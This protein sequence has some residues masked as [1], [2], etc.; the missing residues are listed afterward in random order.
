MNLSVGERIRDRNLFHKTYNNNFI[1]LYFVHF[2]FYFLKFYSLLI[3]IVDI[4]YLA[5]LSLNLTNI[6]LNF[7]IELTYIKYTI[8]IL[9]IFPITEI[10]FYRKFIFSVYL[11]Y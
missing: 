4:L 6:G 2:N 1:L 11:S 10:F 7:I 9:D 8:K 3:N 5:Q